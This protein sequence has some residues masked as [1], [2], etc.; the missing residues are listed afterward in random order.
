MRVRILAALEFVLILPAALFMTA[1]V[2]RN[3]QPLQ[4][5]AQQLVMWYSARMWT[6]WVLLLALPFA[7]VATG[8]ATLADRWQSDRSLS[9][10]RAAPPLRAVAAMTLL[11]GGIL[12]IVVLHMAAN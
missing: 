9:A 2:A 12:V 1:L 7:V 10:F 3:L 4:S 6:L 5:I 8:F 11:A